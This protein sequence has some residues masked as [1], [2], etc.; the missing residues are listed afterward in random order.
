MVEKSKSDAV[1]AKPKAKARTGKRAI[2]KAATTK[3]KVQ[4]VAK[5]TTTRKAAPK[6]SAPKKSAA[7]KT[8]AKKAAAK[9]P[10][11]KKTQNKTAAKSKPAPTKIKSVSDIA[12]ALPASLAKATSKPKAKTTKAPVKKKTT[13]KSSKPV[14]KSVKTVAAKKPAVKTP[15]AKKRVAKTSTTQKAKVKKTTVPKKPTLKKIT[16]KTP[17]TKKPT[18]KKTIAKKAIA[19]KPVV[20][21]VAAKKTAV[22][23]TV[24][25]KTAVKKI[26]AKKTVTKKAVAKKVTAKS[27]PIKATSKTPA[28]SKRVRQKTVAPKTLSAASKAKPSRTTLTTLKAALANLE[29]RLQRADAVTQRHVTTLQ[30]AIAALETRT[31]KANSTQKAAL[32]RQVN[33]LTKKLKAISAEARESVEAELKAV[34][35]NSDVTEMAAALSRASSRMDEAEAV[36]SEALRTINLNLA[37]MARAVEAR[38]N[39]ERKARELAETETTARLNAIEEDTANALTQTGEKIEALSEELQKRQAADQTLISEKVNELAVETQAE[40]EGFRSKMDIRVQ[41][42]EA[43][44]ASA[45]DET[46]FERIAYQLDRLNSRL[47]TLERD[48]TELDER[49]QKI[50]S[51]PPAYAPPADVREFEQMEY[52]SMAAQNMTAQGSYQAAP[53]MLAPNQ[54]P[55][56]APMTIPSNV[57]QMPDAFAPKPI[58]SQPTPM[59]A[60]PAPAFEPA[61]EQTPE[62]APEPPKPPRAAHEPEEFVPSAYAP[63]APSQTPEPVASTPPPAMTSGYAAQTPNAQVPPVQPPAAQNLSPQA[64]QDFEP[65]PEP[66]MP[67]DNPAYAEGGSHEMRAE[68]IGG[69]EKKIGLSDKLNQLPISGRNLRVA[70]ATVALGALGLYA[71]KTVLGIGNNNPLTVN[72]DYAQTLEASNDFDPQASLPV[73]LSADT[74]P[75]IGQYADSQAPEVTNEGASTLS[76]AAEAGNPVAQFQLGLAKLQQ[77]QT[78]EGVT[79]VRLAANK[80]LAAAQYRL[81]K[82]YESGEGVSMDLAMARKLTEQAAQGGNRIAMHDLALYYTDGR[83]GV[84]QNIGKAVG[85]FEQ[86]AERGV[87]DSQFNLA[88]LSESGQGTE[89]NIET[90][91]FWYAI[92]SQQGDQSAKKRIDVLGD[93]LAPEQVSALEARIKAFEPKAIDEAAN[94]I[95]RDTPWSKSVGSKSVQINRV[96]QAQSMLTQLGYETGGADGAIGPMTRAAIIKFERDNALPETGTVSEELLD[97]LQDVAGA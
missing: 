5:K 6:K 89:R 50:E 77:G 24:A 79:L 67:Y 71:G 27:A 37:H 91:Y 28:V 47:D 11:V 80:N 52:P 62:P 70:A 68:R 13:T 21:K 64:P 36:Q 74:S 38:I 96:R 82:L 54:S 44:S 33:Q 18:A 75:A 2:A 26:A 94:G 12:S 95:F 17:V 39:D 22:K 20:K 76:A 49:Q 85:W 8:S 23:K 90:A 7:K 78:D 29:G 56:Q 42:L 87:V 83:G 69:T 88:V 97:R 41:R 46:K 14:T 4:P 31:V 1:T 3:S 86:A 19:K 63:P 10:V 72:S 61:T 16:A 48:L 65:A 34:L 81:A 59:S 60:A 58:P 84:E 53:Q 73:D 40:F 25:K 9:K 51:A 66:L 32:T 92:A 57:V 15:I 45:E 55:S 93:T 35:S 43:K 30:D